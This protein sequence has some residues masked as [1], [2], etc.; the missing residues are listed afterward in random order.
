MNWIDLY[1]LTL[2]PSSAIN[3]PD[4]M[5]QTID[6]QCIYDARS[7]LYNREKYDIYVPTSNVDPGLNKKIG[8][9]LER[10]FRMVIG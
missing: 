9:V 1:G 3:I 2:G 6:E 7:I 8:Q 4:E 10:A 5:Q